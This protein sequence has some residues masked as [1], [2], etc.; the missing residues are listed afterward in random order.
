MDSKLQLFLLGVVDELVVAGYGLTPG[1]TDPRQDTDC[2]VL[3][4]VSG[5]TTRAYHTGDHVRYRSTEGQL[6]F[7]GRENEQVK[8]QGQR[9]ELGEI[10]DMLRS[11]GYVKNAVAFRGRIGH[12]HDSFQPGPWLAELRH[13]RLEPLRKSVNFTA[14]TAE[15]VPALAGKVRMHKATAADVGLLE[16]PAAANVVVMKSVVQ[17]LRSEGYLSRPSRSWFSSRGCIPS[18]LATSGRIRCTSSF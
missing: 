11:H 6:E 15:S 9:V 10:K 18:S 3:V 4:T 1:Y 2:F 14:A 17:Y 13:A 12:G 7:F 5:W 8:T 16:P